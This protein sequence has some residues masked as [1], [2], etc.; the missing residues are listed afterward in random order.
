MKNTLDFFEN[1]EENVKHYPRA[2]ELIKKPMVGKLSPLPLR[3]KSPPATIGRILN[4]DKNT[5]IKRY[6]PRI[7]RNQFDEAQKENLPTNKSRAKLV[8][9]EQRLRIKTELMDHCEQP[10]KIDKHMVL[11]DKVKKGDLEYIVSIFAKPGYAKLIDINYKRQD[12]W[13]ALHIACDEGHF[14]IAC[15]LLKFGASVDAVNMFK[16]TPLHLSCIKYFSYIGTSRCA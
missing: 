11:L 9:Q 6:S 12:G 14:K 2:F 3:S 13:T 16:R 4:L 8:H 10:V 7:D 15:T 5:H 1:D